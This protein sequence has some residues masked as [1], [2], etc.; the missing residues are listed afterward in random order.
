MRLKR[1]PISTSRRL[2]VAL[3]IAHLEGA[4][5]GG[6]EREGLNSGFSW[7]GRGAAAGVTFTVLSGGLRCKSKGARNDDRGNGE[8][9]TMP[10]SQVGGLLKH[11]WRQN[12]SSEK[13]QDQQ[14]P[15]A[16]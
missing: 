8:K 3:A 4:R 9:R 16:D 6:R 14:A 11:T 2:V 15:S 7:E 10:S 1:H 13:Q 12:S 5:D